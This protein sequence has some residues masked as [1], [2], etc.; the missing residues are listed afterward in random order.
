MKTDKKQEKEQE[1]QCVY[2]KNL[3]QISLYQFASIIA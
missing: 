1:K 3:T 2:I